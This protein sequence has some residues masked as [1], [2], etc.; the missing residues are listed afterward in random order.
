MVSRHSIFFKL[1]VA[2]FLPPLILAAP[3]FFGAYAPL[4][5]AV[6]AVP[7]AVLLLILSASGGFALACRFVFRGIQA[8]SDF[9]GGAERS[10]GDLTQRMPVAGRDEIAV[11]ARSHNVFTSQIHQIVF[12]LKNI[13]KRSNTIGRELA[14]KA[15]DVALSLE[16]IATDARSIAQRE[17]D[18]NGRITTSREHVGEIRT[19]ILKIVEQIESQA[20]SVD[21]SSAAVEE[22]IASIQSINRIS[23]SKNELITTLNALANE[24]GDDMRETLSAMKEVAS[25]VDLVQDLITVINDVAEK[26]NMLAMNAAI[27]A[28]HAGE[29]G[30]GFSVVAD[31][32]RALA[33]ETAKNADEI[34]AN[35]SSMLKGIESSQELTEKTDRSIR[36]LIDGIK[37]MSDSLTEIIRG[38][39]EMSGGTT[40]ITNALTQLVGITEEVK[41]NSRVIG[42]KSDEIDG[43]MGKVIGISGESMQSME[44]FTGKI[45]EIKA[46]T[47]YISRAGAENADNISIVDQEVSRFKI[48]DTATLKSGDGQ[49]LIQWNK[50]KKEIPPRPD[51]PRSLPE[52]EAA[53]WYDL[54]YAGWHTDKV[55][56]PE[57]PADGA[58]GKRVLL[59]ESCDHPYHGAYKAGC[60]KLAASFGV[61]LETLNANYSP[62]L[63]A[64]QVD[65]AIRRKPDLIILTPTSVKESTDWFRKIN[66]RGIPVIGSNTTPNDEGFKYILGW[67]GPDDW[68]Q[69]RLLA[70]EF[71]DFM[72]KAGAFAIVR[73][74]KGNSNYFSRTHSILTELRKI[75]PDMECLAMESALK[76]DETRELVS[77]WLKK[78]GTTLK[79]LCCSDPGVSA[80]GLCKAVREAGRDDIVVVSSGNS[81]VTQDLVKSGQ[82]KAITFQSAEGDGALAMEMAIDWFNGIPIEPI[83]YLPMGLIKRDNVDAYYPAQW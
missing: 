20:A 24:G 32:I 17:R 28:A 82:I 16:S 56:I 10:E 66:E 7:L 34:N 38:L 53:H 21:Q 36:Q 9:L 4:A 35:L 73:H 51:K 67:T 11:I 80:L 14:D 25:S 78:Y 52:H 8:L 15:Q 63:Q 43:V 42:T 59:L 5:G 44:A 64:R 23:Q 6:G 13:V 40:E 68:G 3:A 49:D 26:T 61:R 12:K 76:E 50:K 54:E 18:L 19:A 74:A 33:E 45:E 48:I 22:T 77:T 75:A 70:R 2:F 58:E 37:D 39:S 62:E 72:D 83:R 41:D 1:V 81:R 69:F 27:E 71:A 47:G 60:A 57:S 65:E 55:N 79:G 31:E 29:H 46:S 30:R